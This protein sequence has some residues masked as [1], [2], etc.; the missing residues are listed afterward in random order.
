MFRWLQYLSFYPF[1]YL[2]NKY[3]EGFEILLELL[4]TDFV[5]ML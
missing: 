2:F 3:L 5:N 1:T 4:S